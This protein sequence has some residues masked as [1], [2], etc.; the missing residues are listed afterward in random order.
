[1]MPVTTEHMAMA[2]STVRRMEA[3]VPLFARTLLATP[4]ATPTR[5]AVALLSG[6]PIFMRIELV[7]AMTKAVTM[8][9]TS[10]VGT[11]SSA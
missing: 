8:Q 5:K 9:L 2:T 7:K 11:P 6:P 10:A 4:A 3:G 1:M